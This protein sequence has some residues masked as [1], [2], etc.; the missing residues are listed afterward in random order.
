MASTNKTTNYN[1]PLYVGTDIPNPLTDWN[2]AMNTIDSTMKEIGDSSAS[3]IH[4]T[5]ELATVVGSAPLETTH[6][7]LT[8]AVNELKATDDTMNARLTNDEADI[9][10]LPSGLVG[11][12]TSVTNLGNTVAGL[13][14]RVTAIEVQNGTQPLQTTAQTLSGAVNELDNADTLL[15][16]RVTALEQASGAVI[17][18]EMS[19]ESENAVQNKVITNYVDLNDTNL[20][21]MMIA[22]ERMAE[23]EVKAGT[24][25]AGNT[26]LTLTFVNE[27]IGAN[28]F[29]SVYTKTFGVN[30]VDVTYTSNTVTVEIEAQASDTDVSVMV[31]NRNIL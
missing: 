9:A 24:I 19:T 1:L 31:F 28:T 20:M 8:E 16:S 3:A 4:G 14:N 21:N 29:I 27:T 13:G 25:T 30:P 12:N 22:L 6:K 18:D 23:G 10:S 15:D 26:T 11:T 17:D 7:N 5:E 2:G